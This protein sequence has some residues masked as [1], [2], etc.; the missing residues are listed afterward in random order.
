MWID[1]HCHLDAREFGGES[2]RVA[3]DA[4]K[5]G[6]SMIVIPAIDVANFDAVARLAATAPNASY[7]LG[8]H[9]ICVPQAGE[10]DL[11]TLRSRVTAA[12]ADPNFVAIGEVGLDFFLP[13][14]AEPAMREKQVYFFREQLKIAR[15]FGLPILTHVR[16]SQDQVLKHIRQIPPAGGIAHA[17]NG[18]FQQ[19]QGYIDIGFKLGF[20]GNLTFTR[21]LQIR[22]LAEQLPLS[23]IVMETDAPDIAPHWLHPGV[24]TPD[25]VPRIAEVLAQLR[26]I[27]LDEVQAATTANAH[28]VM[29]R[30]R[31]LL[32]A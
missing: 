11:A 7:G 15:E 6:V 12:M 32:A 26:G 3:A 22:R 20:G 27:G 30:L 14:L 2:L 17:F 4:G 8:I 18:S 13:H 10:D 16:K 9:P 25:Q 5:A 29:P 23:A 28:H 19:A 21:A 31:A 1:T 24:N